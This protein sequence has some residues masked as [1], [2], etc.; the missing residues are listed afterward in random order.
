MLL[1]LIVLLMRDISNKLLTI[2][3]SILKTMSATKI[4]YSRIVI[5][6]ASKELKSEDHVTLG[7]A[8]ITVPFFL[9]NHVPAK[10]S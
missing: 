8:E 2:N 7:I 4:C 9:R 10:H 5:M 1:I 3:S 6:I